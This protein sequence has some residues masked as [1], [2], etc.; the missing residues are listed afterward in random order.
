[1]DVDVTAREV[2]ARTTVALVVVRDGIATW[3][4]AAARELVEPHGGSWADPD[5]PLAAI[6]A[7]PPG[8]VRTLTSWVPPGHAD[9]RWWQATCTTLHGPVTGLL[10]EL[11][12]HTSKVS[13]ERSA[14]TATPHWRLDRLEALAHMGSWVW[15]IVEDHLEWSE[16]LLAMFGLPG[17]QPLNFE[18][19][20]AMVHPED[21]TIV[22]TAMAEGLATGK[23]FSYVH[24]MSTA[25]SVERIFECHGEILTDPAGTPIR[26]L[27][28]ARDVTEE[29][30]NRDELAYLAEHDPL[31]GIANRRRV[32]AQLAERSAD[33]AGATLLLIDIDHF[34][35]I[36]DLRGHAVG[37]RVIRCIAE[38]AAAEL[39]PGDLLG[40][41][42]G[43]EF[44][45]ILPGCDP[46]RGLGLGER[47]CDAV[48][49]RLLIEAGSSLRVTVSVGVSG[50]PTGQDVEASLAQADLALYEAKN[51]GRGRARL[52]APDQYQQALARVGIAHRVATA[53]DDGTMDLDAQPIVDL[54]TGRV[55]R[56]ELLVRLRDG[57]SPELGP[58]DFLPAAE[59]S[60]LVQRLDR[61]VLE[62]AVRALA[63]PAARAAELR[64]EVNISARSLQDEDLGGWV[65][66]LLAA[67]D[68]RPARLGLEM[69]ETM[70]ITNV[71]AAQRLVRQLTGAGCGFAL[72]DFG[73]GFGSFSHL[74]HLPFTAVKI[75]GEFVRRLDSD[76][77]DRALVA[78]VVGV[79]GLLGMRTVAEQVERAALVQPLRELGVHDGQGFHLGAPRPLAELLGV[80]G[81]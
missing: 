39:G 44:A 76:P 52:F 66:H 45:A 73:S 5:G 63:A 31:T 36:N 11:V 65:L 27:G 16:A 42:G 47:L 43:D 40:R 54:A 21:R 62:R 79:A 37:D 70:A 67:H 35:D 13:A 19:F 7:V 17:D 26:V 74:K 51:A 57:R 3:F 59:R 2:A 23:P 18:L 10:Y 48:A 8:A 30:R 6:G 72:D 77:V 4:N 61:W 29:H 46:G 64:F 55:T 22:D 81:G 80:A 12:D 1:V 71:P 9:G 50:V 60:D 69:T 25:G 33:P 75:D 38:T 56:S 28:T 24:R 32:T 78:A 49:G 58:A 41:L 14:G 15:D 34:K 20:R 53:L 68:V